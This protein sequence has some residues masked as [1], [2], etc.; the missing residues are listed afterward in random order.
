MNNFSDHLLFSNNIWDNANFLKQKELHEAGLKKAM[1]T[2][3]KELL[4]KEGLKAGERRERLL[5]RAGQMG[6]IAQEAEKRQGPYSRQLGSALLNQQSALSSAG[7]VRKNIEDIDVQLYS[8]DKDLRNRSTGPYMKQSGLG[9]DVFPF[10][11]INVTPQ[12]Y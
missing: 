2:G 9:P 3:D 12:Q 5:A 4:A 10:R 6:K 11:P 1:K 8:M 7:K